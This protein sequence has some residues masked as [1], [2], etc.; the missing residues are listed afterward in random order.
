MIHYLLNEG[1]LFVS[2]VA[3]DNTL[4]CCGETTE[5]VAENLQLYLKVLLE[6][7]GKDQM[8]TTLGKRL[9][10]ML[11]KRKSLKIEPEGFKLELAKSVKLLGLTIDHN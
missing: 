11:G 7:F 3:D 4:Y 2:N 9:Y 5:D 8:M 10:I 6:R 1:Q